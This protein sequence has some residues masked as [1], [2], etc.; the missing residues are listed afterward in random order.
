VL[1]NSPLMSYVNGEVLWTD[2]GFL[3]AL[4]TG[5]LKAAWTASSQA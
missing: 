4:T 5:R 1:L 2:G 3:S